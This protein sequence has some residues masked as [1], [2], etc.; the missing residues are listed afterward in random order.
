MG[1]RKRQ[2]DFNKKDAGKNAEEA[3]KVFDNL[4]R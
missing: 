1:A 4:F 3:L 2:F